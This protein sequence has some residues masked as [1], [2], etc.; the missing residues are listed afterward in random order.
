[1]P[2]TEP[3]RIEPV[4]DDGVSAVTVGLLLWAAATVVSLVLRDELVQRE[5]QWWVWT[6]LLGLAVGVGLLA[7]TRR[8]ARVYREHRAGLPGQDAGPAG[9]P[10]DVGNG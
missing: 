6:C 3:P 9:A 4:G 1:M 2:E 7:F 5:A 8:R 10:G